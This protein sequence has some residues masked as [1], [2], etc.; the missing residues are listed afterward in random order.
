MRKKE[1]S[2]NAAPVPRGFSLPKSHILRGRT[3]FKSLFTNSKFI[4]SPSVTL[5]YS[6][7]AHPNGEFKLAFICPKKLG[8][9]VQRNRIKRL[10]REAYRLSNEH[11]LPFG[12]DL[13]TVELHG[14]FI[15]RN[16]KL[17]FDTACK[18]M[19]TLLGDLRTRV[20]AFKPS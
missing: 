6:L 18:E 11:L 16:S 13:P 4:S 2:N 15:A 5:R 20:A 9:A 19:E 17:T 3:N 10:L 7:K 12:G 1:Q 14:A 8:S